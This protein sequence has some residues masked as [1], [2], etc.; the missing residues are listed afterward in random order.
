MDGGGQS[1]AALGVVVVQ[2]GIVVMTFG[3][4]L[5]KHNQT[6]NIAEL[7]A[8]WKGLRLVKHL[9]KPVKI[10]SDS[11]YAINSICGSF[12][13]KKN[14]ELIDSIIDYVKQYPVPIEF[15]KV[16]GHVGLP[17]NEMADGIASWF[18]NTNKGEGKQ[19]CQKKRK[20][21]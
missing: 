9:F 20:K 16:K 15:V 2:K 17:F 5:G 18:L 7:N 10:Y 11:M 13:G 6:N 14:R 21:S 1:S 3:A 12:N 4:F 8:I 19:I